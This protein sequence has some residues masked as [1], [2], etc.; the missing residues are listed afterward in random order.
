MGLFNE[1]A[2]VEQRALGFLQGGRPPFEDLNELERL[3][4]RNVA[5]RLA[6]TVFPPLTQLELFLTW[7]C[8]L[9]C[10]YC[11]VAD[12][13]DDRRDVQDMS[14]ATAQD[15]LDFLVE[16]S[17]H[18]RRLSVLFF[19][20]EPLVRFGTIRRIVERA[21]SLAAG[22]DKEIKFSLTT[23]GLLLNEAKLRF[24]RDNGIRFL[25]SIDGTEGSHDRHRRQPNGVG[26]HA[27]LM[28]RLPLFKR[29]QPWL[30]TRMTVHPE[31]APE[32]AA[33]VRLLA[34]AGI[35]Q[36]LIAPSEGVAWTDEAIECY[37]DQLLAVCRYVAA[38]QADG[39]PI[40][41]SLLDS[42]SGDS[43]PE[44]AGRWGCRAGR[45]TIAVTP[46]RAVYPCSKLV[47][48]RGI[49]DASRLGSLDDGLTNVAL[50]LALNDLGVSRQGCRVCSL[51]D[52]CTGGCYY[53]N[54]LETGDLFGVSQGWECR[55]GA[56]HRRLERRW[57]S[58]N[59]AGGRP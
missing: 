26:S 59:P 11:F 4:V 43:S 49:A 47:G 21:A 8:P 52:R 15:A 24:L 32:L 36:F 29:Y 5:G 1:L 39:R 37:G 23:N 9:R 34:E 30:G 54:M 50:R 57:A 42:M 38:A 19:G 46:D 45:H 3:V 41:F 48:T 2:G 22:S 7:R 35:N 17:R 56:L 18:K 40:R 44:H 14:D 58:G 10:G 33:G 12:K 53:N 51:A 27:L 13:D 6:R 16:M 28:E 20:G 25:L 31:T 55:F